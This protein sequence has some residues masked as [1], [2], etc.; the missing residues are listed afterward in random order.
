M[1]SVHDGCHYHQWLLHVLV[2]VIIEAR[3]LIILI[4]SCLSSWVNRLLQKLRKHSV[5]K[6]PSLLSAVFFLQGQLILLACFS[7]QESKLGR[8]RSSPWTPGEQE[9]RGSWTWRSWAPQGRLCRVWWH[10]W[11]AGRAARPSSSHG[12]KGCMPSTWPMTDIL[13]PEALTWWRPRCHLIPPRSVFHFCS[14]TCRLLADVTVLLQFCLVKTFRKFF[15]SQR[16]F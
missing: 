15:C 7:L 6:E 13:C 12:R 5:S 1:H 8:T 10:P 4:Q 3:M 9:A 2:L 16:Q 14:R 11:Q